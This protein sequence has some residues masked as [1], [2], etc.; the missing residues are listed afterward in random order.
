MSRNRRGFTLV[1]VMI[2]A[3]LA[4]LITLSAV[5][6]V[7]IVTKGREKV[8][9]YSEVNA[10]VRYVAD[11]IKRDLRNLSRA[12]LSKK[13]VGEW[14]PTDIGAVPSL[15]I[16]TNRWSNVRKGQPEG[17]VYEVQYTIAQQDGRTVMLRRVWPDPNDA[18]G[19]SG[20]VSVLSDK[21]VAFD[22]K[23]LDDK[24]WR[25]D[26]PEDIGK[27][28]QIMVVNIVAQ[29]PG[30]SQRVAKSFLVN[31]PRQGTPVA[32]TAGLPS[33]SPAT[34]TTGGG[35]GSGAAAAGGGRGMQGGQGGRGGQNGPGRGPRGP[36]GPD[37]TTTRPNPDRP[38]PD[39][40]NPDR[41]NPDRPNPDRPNPDRPNNNPQPGQPPRTPR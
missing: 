35:Q 32:G 15:T 10:E 27:D 17:D 21:I 28:C 34:A 33:T 39:R 12:S 9:R 8:E 20:V 38:N 29:V 7:R 24:E 2:A 6:A 23:Y 19:P 11:S 5:A 40:P 16:Y 3:V 31:F 13:F 1:E 37:D 26:W 41:P 4:S 18:M 36:G 22:I 30:E 14:L 25:S